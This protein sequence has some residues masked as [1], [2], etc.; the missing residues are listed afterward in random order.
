MAELH[1][2]TS[3]GQA[4]LR[5]PDRLAIHD[6][7]RGRHPTPAIPRQDRSSNIGQ[8]PDRALDQVFEATHRAQSHRIVDY[9]LGG[10][11]NFA[12]DRIAT[13]Q[14]LAHA[15]H[16]QESAWA[17]RSFLHRAVRTLLT[18]GIRQFVDLGT[19]V[20][21]AGSTH[22]IATGSNSWARVIYVDS[23]PLTH[24]L[25]TMLLADT[26]HGAVQSDARD[27]A[28]CAGFIRATE[29]LDLRLPVCVLAVGLLDRLDDHEAA[30]VLTGWCSVVP[31]GSVLVLSHG[32]D[33]GMGSATAAAN[34][35][36]RAVLAAHGIP[37][38]SRSA[39]EL[40]TLIGHTG[41]QLERPLTRA[42][43]WNPEGPTDTADPTRPEATVLVATAHPQGCLPAPLATT[44]STPNGARHG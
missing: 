31:P 24:T 39:A 7:S 27:A 9:M 32:T 10:G 42:P 40:G 17:T 13:H 18:R 36:A 26:P 1:P 34:R 14:A 2:V 25:A 20:A 4:P 5:G 37:L 28:A 6:V 38:R 15:P 19:T 23:D 16:L 43:L 29:V 30:S 35:A 22:Q 44:Q 33:D 12:A 41:W 21:A 3:P 8:A 11:L